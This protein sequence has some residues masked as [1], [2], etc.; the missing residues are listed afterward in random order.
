M[1]PRGRSRVVPSTGRNLAVGLFVGLLGACAYVVVPPSM[2][3]GEGARRKQYLPTWLPGANA[4]AQ[5]PPPAA[6][7]PDKATR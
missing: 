2:S 5:Q 6:P 1:D 7:A 3:E 4:G